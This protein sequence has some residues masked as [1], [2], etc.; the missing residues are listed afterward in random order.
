[1]N[2]DSNYD[3]NTFRNEIKSHLGLDIC[4][5]LLSVVSLALNV[6]MMSIAVFRRRGQWA[7]DEVLLLMIG[8]TD[9]LLAAFLILSQLWKWATDNAIVRDG[10]CWCRLSSTLVW[11]TTVATLDLTA[12]LAVMRFMII[13]RGYTVAGH[14]WKR[15]GVLITTLVWILFISKDMLS[16]A[17]V[18]PSGMYCASIWGSTDAISILY[19]TA[20]LVLV[21]PPLFVVPFCY[22]AITAHYHRLIAQ[23]DETH[24]QFTT[25]LTLKLH[26]MVLI[27]VLYLLALLPEYIQAFVSF[28]F[29]MKLTSWI[30]GLTK[31]S[32]FCV[33][34][35]NVIFAL[36]FHED[37][38][39]ELLTLVT[40]YDTKFA[41]TRLR[42]LPSRTSC[43]F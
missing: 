11:G 15:L 24:K 21:I 3:S 33:T 10:S 5:L 2:L 35:V 34:I 36:L 31:I 8:S 19:Y 7:I 30:D 23:M 43:E 42:T 1:M 20:M 41:S 18:F 27:I 40:E 9:A 4:L 22:A 28:A 32:I 37:I 39:R 17:R 38:N 26:G 16:T 13:V 29:T 12:L 6:L 25:N 14:T